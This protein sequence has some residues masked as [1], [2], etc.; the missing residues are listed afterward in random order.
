MLSPEGEPLARKYYSE[1]TARDLDAD[2]MVRGYEFEAGKY[3]VVTDEE[4]ERLAPEKSRDIDLKTFVPAESIPPLH[5]DRGYF[6]T[7]GEGSE[8]AY[9]LLAAT[10]EKGDKAGLATFVMRGKEYLVAIFAEHEIL[11]AETMRFADEL[12][13]PADVGLPK[14]PKIPAATV[15]K[16]EKLIST[17]SKKQLSEAWL[18][19]EQTERLLKLVKKKSAQRK[20]VVEVE[21]ESHEEAKVVDLVAILKR[22]L[23]GKA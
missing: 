17:R 8:K 7:P 15:R 21:T 19:D 23:A 1:K 13:S 10:M 11:R 4:L 20:N 2:Q 12:R 3:V 9:K 22:S 16:F 18:K 14:K 6:L 5:F